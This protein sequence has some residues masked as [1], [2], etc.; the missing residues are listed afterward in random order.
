MDEPTQERSNINKLLSYAVK[1][2][3]SDLHLR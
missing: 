3:A 2:S 1:N